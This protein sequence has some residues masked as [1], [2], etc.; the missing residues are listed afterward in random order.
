MGVVEDPMKIVEFDNLLTVVLGLTA[1]Q[2]AGF[3]VR[4]VPGLGKSNIP[5][6]VIGGVLGALCVA[7]ARKLFDVEVHFASRLTD[8]MLLVFFTSVGL[9]AKLSA[10]KAGGK[11]LV[12]VCL[13]TVLLI[14][15]QNATGIL[16]AM[17][18]GAN[19]YYGVLVGSI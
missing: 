8:F 13:A 17:G 10:L 6:P 1:L 11:P 7:A 2:V 9:S 15:A 5:T 12:I 16:V 18:F 3:L 19:P 4:R 14:V